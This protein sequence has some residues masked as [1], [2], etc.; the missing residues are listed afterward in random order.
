MNSH[1]MIT[2]LAF[3]FLAG[4]VNQEMVPP[5][6]MKPL[7]AAA[8]TLSTPKG[9][10]VAFAPGDGKGPIVINFWA[11]WCAPC[12]EEL[13]LLERLYRAHQRN[14]VRFIAVNVKES[15]QTVNSFLET[16]GYTIPI[17][18]DSDGAMVEQ[19]GVFGLPST[20]FIDAAGMI[21]TKH[22]GALTREI[23]YDSIEMITGK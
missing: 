8:L 12:V 18:L 20:Y 5:P 7:R 17:L 9:A 4:C 6:P 21:R 22:M 14:G 13:P 1:L 3:L 11:T 10:T 23:A 15:V 2:A 16:Y 19:Y